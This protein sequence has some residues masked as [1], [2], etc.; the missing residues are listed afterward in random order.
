MAKAQFHRHQRVWVECVGAWATIDKITPIWAKG[1]DEPVR[2]T[3]DVGFGR[4]FLGH[5]LQAEAPAET[6]GLDPKDPAW[7]IL[8][9]RNKWQQPEDCAHHPFPGTYPVVV[10]DA[11]DWGGWRVPGSEYDRDPARFEKQARLIS[12]APQMARLAQRLKAL[13]SEAPEDAPPAVMELAREAHRLLK[14]VSG[15]RQTGERQDATL[16]TEPVD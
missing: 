15:G 16:T 14:Y 12:A 8:R 13:V 7:R 9:T 1:F 2:I 3:Y 11:Q 5:E 4:E 6:P 10:T